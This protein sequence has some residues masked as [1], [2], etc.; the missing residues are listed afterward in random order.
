MARRTK[1]IEKDRIEY[2]VDRNDQ[3]GRS[4]LCISGKQYCFAGLFQGILFL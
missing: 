4:L 3:M 2:P 1:A